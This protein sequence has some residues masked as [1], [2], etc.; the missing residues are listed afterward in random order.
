MISTSV[1]QTPT[2][3]ASTSTDPSRTAGSGMSS[4]HALPG[5]CG[6]TVMAFM[7]VTVPLWSSLRPVGAPDAHPD[8]I[9]PGAR[10]DE[11]RPA[12]R[13]TEGDVGGP[14]LVGYPDV[15]N[16]PALRVEHHHPVPSQVEMP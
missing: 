13:A 9:E 10:G 8:A 4:R 11:E 5:L 14:L 1:P 3:T 12:I 6:S 7:C 16:L 15:I 2:A